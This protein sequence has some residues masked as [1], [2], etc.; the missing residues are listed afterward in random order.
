M[1]LSEA[2]PLNI[3]AR[4][5]EDYCLSPSHPRGRH[6]ARVFAHALGIV[7]R[8][9]LWLREQLLQTGPAAEVINR[10]TDQFGERLTADIAISRQGRT[11]VVRSVWMVRD[12][13]VN[14]VTCWVL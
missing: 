11:A 3:D 6:K 14:L 5:L 8:D 2:G 1:K 7:Q 13:S 9:A 10:E 12:A 4:K